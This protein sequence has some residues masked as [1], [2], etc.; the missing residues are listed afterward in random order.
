MREKIAQI[1]AENIT[2][3]PQMGGYVV[4][5]AIEKLIHLMEDE[6]VE[7]ADQILKSEYVTNG[8]NWLNVRNGTTA[9]SVGLYKK[10]RA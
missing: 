7:F 6:A 4:H 10:W 2:F 5:G 1:L 3:S 9:T 8:G